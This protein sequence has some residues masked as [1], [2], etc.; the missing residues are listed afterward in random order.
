M[1]ERIKEFPYSIVQLGQAEELPIPELCNDVGRQFSDRSFYG[2]LILRRQN[3]RREKRC[4]I[5]IRQ[6]LVAAVHYR[7]F[8][9]LMTDYA[10]L[11]VVAD[12][13]SGDP[14]EVLEHMHTHSNCSCCPNP[15]P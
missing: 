1:I 5:V 7:I 11:E 15:R 6:F 3:P 10:S 13:E 14:A 4:F 2:C 9:L 8:A 12:K